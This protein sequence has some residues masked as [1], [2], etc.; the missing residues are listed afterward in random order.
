M[1]KWYQGDGIIL[2]EDIWAFPP[3]GVR[4]RWLYMARPSCTC[5]CSCG[6]LKIRCVQLLLEAQIHLEAFKLRCWLWSNLQKVLSLMAKNWMVWI[7]MMVMKDPWSILSLIGFHYTCACRNDICAWNWQLRSPSKLKSE[8]SQNLQSHPP[9]P[10]AL[11]SP[12]DWYRCQPATS[13][14]EPSEPHVVTVREHFT[15][16]RL[17][18]HLSFVVLVPSSFWWHS[19]WTRDDSTETKREEETKRMKGRRIV[20]EHLRQVDPSPGIH[21]FKGLEKQNFCVVMFSLLCWYLYC[22][23]GRPF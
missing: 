21:L 14:P 6:C 16:F 9:P 7:H 8:I 12:S 18:C 15:S 5:S 11:S 1:I 10:T 13:S 19:I 22:N 20:V 23:H 2:F 17:Q 3:L 4:Q